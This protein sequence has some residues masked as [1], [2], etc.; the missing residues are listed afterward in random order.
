MI[1]VTAEKPSL[2]FVLIFLLFSV[3]FLSNSLRLW[4]N[5]DKY[6]QDLRE[7][8]M[9]SPF[10]FKEF[11]LRRLENRSRWETG[12]KIYSVV[13]VLAVVGADILVVLSY[14]G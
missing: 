8:L 7:S 4:F 2:G 5:T 6:Y 9:N 1:L 12:Q 11:F 10:P 13:G 3:M 14:L